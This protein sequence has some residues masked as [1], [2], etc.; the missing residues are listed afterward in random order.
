MKAVAMDRQSLFCFLTSTFILLWSISNK[1]LWIDEGA[2]AVYALQPNFSDFWSH[3]NTDTNSDCQMPLTMLI[4]WVVDKFAGSSEWM[5]RAPNLVWSWISL[6]LLFIIGRNKEMI[7]LPLLFAIQPFLWFYMDEARP[8][9]FQVMCGCFLLQALINFRSGEK[10]WVLSF[11]V[12]SVLL[13]HATLLAPITLFAVIGSGLWIAQNQKINYRLQGKDKLLLSVGFLLCLPIGFYYLQTIQRGASGAQLWE[14]S[15]FNLGYLFYEL[16]GFTGLG[17]A[18]SVLRDYATSRD[19]I[20][21][22]THYPFNWVV[23]GSFGLLLLV[24]VIKGVSGVRTRA[25]WPDFLSCMT[26]VVLTVGCFIIISMILHK[27]F[28]ARHLAPVFPFFVYALALLVKSYNPTKFFFTKACW[29]VPLVMAAWVTSSL[30]IRF[31][32]GQ[33]SEDY[34]STAH[35]VKQVLASGGVVAWSA[36]WHCAYY[37]GLPVDQ[38][39]ISKAENFILLYGPKPSD[40]DALKEPDLVVIGKKDIYDREG[41]IQK[42]IFANRYTLSTQIPS[43]ALYFK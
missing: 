41:R 28:W 13:A 22:L 26:V 3:L 10:S 34:R 9:I 11:I 20:G 16:S 39:G 24:I 4:A 33:A 35:M 7:W 21:L 23:V 18:P 15:V 36:S 38:E 37:Y 19:F 43:F 6:G 2:T 8:Y 32:T 29:V 12:G 17:P 30:T 31:W 1:S 27:A 40:P 25:D 42:W 14:I 5:L